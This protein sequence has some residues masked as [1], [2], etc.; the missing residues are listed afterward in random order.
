MPSAGKLIGELA[1]RTRTGASI[2][3]IQRNGEN[4]VN[5]GPDEELRPGDEVLLLGNQEN[6]ESARKLLIGGPATP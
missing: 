4:I 1:L 5:P 2:V 6:L 3:G